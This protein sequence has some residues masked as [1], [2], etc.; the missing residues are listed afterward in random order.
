MNRRTVLIAIPLVVVG[1][2]GTNAQ[3]TLDQAKAYASDVVNAVSAAAQS[4]VASPLAKDAT[5][6]SES[7]AGLQAL[8]KAIQETTVATTARSVITEII[9]GVNELLPLVM[10]FLG[11]AG[12]YIP[13]A[14]A[15]LQ[16]FL[17]ALPPPVD[18]PAT[19]PAEL[20]RFA[21]TYKHR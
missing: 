10:P 1:C 20:H 3:V 4:Y 6:V 11:V 2:T 8:N 19:P 5:A 21:L 15:V 13:M 12:P 18:A 14:L 17:A 7:V 9:T 16:A